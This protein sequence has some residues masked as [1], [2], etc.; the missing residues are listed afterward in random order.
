MCGLLGFMNF[1]IKNKKTK[2]TK[3]PKP[4]NEEI[5]DQ[6]EDQIS[7]GREGFGILMIN[8][9]NEIELKRA[10]EISKAQNWRI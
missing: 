10:T 2:K 1:P 4:V 5:I 6:L 9:K 8:K 7:R 3:Q